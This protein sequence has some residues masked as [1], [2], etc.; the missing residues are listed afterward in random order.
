MEEFYQLK[1]EIFNCN[2]IENAFI[3]A[4]ELVAGCKKRP[5]IKKL[6]W[7]VSYSSQKYFLVCCLMHHFA[8]YCHQGHWNILLMGSWD[9]WQ[10]PIVA[11]KWGQG[12]APKKSL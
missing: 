5:F 8:L 7:K 2:Q 4:K 12:L 6:F 9:E 1:E 11:W 3:F 10:A